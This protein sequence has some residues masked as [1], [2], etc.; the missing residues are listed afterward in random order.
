MGRHRL[1]SLGT[2]LATLALAAPLLG[3]APTAAADPT[4]EREPAGAERSQRAGTPTISLRNGG[5]RRLSGALVGGNLRWSPDGNRRVVDADG[6]LRPGVL[7]Y[8]REVGLGSARFPGGTVANMYDFEA[9][10]GPQA[11][12]GCQTSAGFAL[13]PYSEVAPEDNTYGLHEHMDYL[14]AIGGAQANILVPMIN[15]TAQDAGNWVRYMLDETGPWAERRAANGRTR[16]WSVP[17]WEVG[18]EPYISNQRYW[19]SASTAKRLQQYVEGGVQWQDPADT[20]T[21][22]FE[23]DRTKLFAVDGCDL[24]TPVETTDEPD[25]T[26]RV[27]FGPIN[28]A[29]GRDPYLTFPGG[30]WTYV[31]DLASAGPRERVFT[32]GGPDRDRVVFGDGERGAIPP[33]GQEPDIS[34]LSGPHPGY[35]QIRAAM[36]RAAGGTPIRVCS[37]WGKKP[38]AQA[39]FVAYMKK[40]GLAWDCLAKHS[41]A[42]LPGE[43]DDRSVNRVVQAQ[44]DRLTRE[45]RSLIR[46]S[47]KRPVIVTE[48]GHL[49]GSQKNPD[50]EFRGSWM[51]TLYEM[52]LQLGQ[53]RLGVR[54]SSTSNWNSPFEFSGTRMTG[55]STRGQALRLLSGLRG[56]AVGPAVVSPDGRIGSGDASFARLSTFSTCTRS[57]G[58]LRRSLV[59]INR[60]A[61]SAWRG[62]VAVPGRG[63]SWTLQRS[64]ITGALA[65][66]GPLR[67]KA[68]PV[69]RFTSTSGR[70]VLPARSISLVRLTGR[71]GGVGGCG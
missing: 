63:G 39:D 30:R 25:Q 18:N 29:R 43:D 54:L 14:G 40:R 58:A 1:L 46:A 47:G 27:R 41:Y 34:Y 71:G 37:A 24:R 12:R 15:R 49:A 16:P 38:S 45:L 68:A 31:A 17:F 11:Q 5:G 6:D 56:Q 70:L 52:G 19:R 32:V 2:T 8:S 23:R 44:G 35:V 59:V 3:G 67:P 60:D 4:S 9:G 64:T 26:Y 65:S 20:G 42:G 10:L 61:R 21:G 57:D 28:T 51:S 55:L 33:A 13:D 53:A 22:D 7:R 50:E 66:Q 48:F 69:T 62:R 36:R